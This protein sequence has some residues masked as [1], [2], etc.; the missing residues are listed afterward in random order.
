IIASRPERYRSRLVVSGDASIKTS[1]RF[2]RFLNEAKGRRTAPPTTGRFSGGAIWS[3]RSVPRRRAIGVRLLGLDALPSAAPIDVRRGL[4]DLACAAPL[5]L[6]R[7]ARAAR[8]PR[9]LRPGESSDAAGV[10]S[11]AR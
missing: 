2:D 1:A 11:A 8:F 7:A 6:N 5:S 3:K 4:A 10:P 9:S